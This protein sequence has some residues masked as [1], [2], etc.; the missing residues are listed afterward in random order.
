M[1]A[2]IEA[3]IDFMTTKSELMIRT[4]FTICSSNTSRYF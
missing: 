2:V 3:R 1:C 4:K